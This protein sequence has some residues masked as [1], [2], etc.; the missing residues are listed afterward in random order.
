MGVWASVVAIIAIIFLQGGMEFFGI[1]IL[2]SIAGIMT[3]VILNY[4]GNGTITSELDQLKE[5]VSELDE[6]ID[7]LKKLLEE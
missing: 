1:L 3:S 2:L 4:E 5:T 6:K 7:E